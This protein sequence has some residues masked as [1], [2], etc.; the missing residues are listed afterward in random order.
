MNARSTSDSASNFGAI[1]EGWALAAL[2]DVC[3]T[4]ESV[5]PKKV[6]AHTLFKYVDVSSIDNDGHVIVEPKVIEKDKA[7]SRAR[8]LIRTDDVVF[9][10]VRVYLENIGWVDGALDGHI[11]STAFCVLR[12]KAGITGR[13]LYRHVSSRDFIDRLLP[14]QRGNSPPA[15][16]EVDIRRQLIPLP[17]TNEQVRI[18]DKLDIPH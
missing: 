1:P 2:D 7:P 11:A 10:T 9:S 6:F 16:L 8:Q 15:V 12:G 17:P 14:L 5:D 13:Y 4:V 18:A 3:G